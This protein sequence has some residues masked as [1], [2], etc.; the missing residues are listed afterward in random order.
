MVTRPLTAPPGCSA[1]RSCCSLT[2]LAVGLTE[3]SGL[4]CCAAAGIAMITSN[5]SDNAPTRKRNCAKT[6]A[7]PLSPKDFFFEHGCGPDIRAAPA[8][9]SGRDGLAIRSLPAPRTGAVAALRHALL[10]DLRD[11]L[12]VTRQQRL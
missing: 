1:C 11:D 9:A 2:E 7:I 6:F 4:R 10:V 12:A 5:A 8:V 3:P